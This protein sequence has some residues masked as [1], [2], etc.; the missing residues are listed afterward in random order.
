MEE[1]RTPAR[2]AVVRL[3]L[4]KLKR[5]PAAVNAAA[6]AALFAGGWAALRVMDLLL[7]LLGVA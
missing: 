6:F 3:P 1:L 7:R 4:R 5:S 2:G